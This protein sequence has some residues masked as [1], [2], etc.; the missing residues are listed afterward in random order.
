MSTNSLGMSAR[1]L[2]VFVFAVQAPASQ[3]ASACTERGEA[4]SVARFFKRCRFFFPL[5]NRRQQLTNARNTKH[6]AVL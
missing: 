4:S 2:I 5:A 1:R 3:P 6:C